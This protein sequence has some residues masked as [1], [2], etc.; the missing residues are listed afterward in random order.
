[1]LS[2]LRRRNFGL[3]W[4]GCLISFSGDWMLR[5]ALPAYV[6]Q[7]TGSTLATGIM[8]MVGSLPNILFGSLAGVFVDRWDR[9]RTLVLA[10]L[11]LA[12]SLVPLLLVRSTEWLSL[13]YVTAFAES[14]LGLVTGPAEN[15]LLPTL[16][17]DERLLAAN[18][19]NALNNNL[20]RLL[21]PVLGGFAVGTLGLGGVALID[22]GTYAL[23]AGLIALIKV[24][25]PARIE[26]APVTPAAPVTLGA[27]WREWAAGLRLIRGGRVVGILFACAACMAFGEGVM[28]VLFVP[29]VTRVLGGAAIE[30]GYLMSAQAIGGLLG[31]VVMAQIGHRAAPAR[32]FGPA[33]LVFGLIDLVIFNYPAFWSGFGIA[34]VLFVVVGLPGAAVSASL[35]TLLQGAVSEEYRGRIF[36]TLGTTFALLTLCGMLLASAAGDILGIVPVISLQGLAHVAAG[37]LGWLLLWSR[38]PTP[39]E[40]SIAT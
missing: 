37:V 11:L 4:W 18:A 10:N 23:A 39:P 25:R 8:F 7:L 31:G 35:T 1:M 19:L 14:M 21:G 17:E 16:V 30:L 32:L 3:L 2:L 24:E 36:G 28:A 5:I 13:V 40:P 6:Y 29:F 26:D 38:A 20:A 15:A 9:R 33:A 12:A 27:V 22:A 34:L